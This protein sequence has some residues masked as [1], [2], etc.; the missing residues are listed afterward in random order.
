MY[1]TVAAVFETGWTIRLEYLGK[2]TE[3]VLSVAT[4]IS[5][6]IS[7]FLLAKA[8]QS[9]PIETA[10]ALWAGIEAAAAAILGVILFDETSIISRFGFIGLIIASVD[11]LEVTGH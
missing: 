6:A 11:G 1:P 2:F 9:L 7:V 10:Y 4:V 5:M 8:V 3:L